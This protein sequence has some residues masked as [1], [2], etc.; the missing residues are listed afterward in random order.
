MSRRAALITTAAPSAGEQLARRRRKYVVMMACRIPCLV[1]AG[2]TAHVWWLALAFLAISVPLPWAAVLIAN[3][4]PARRAE[5]V[6]RVP[7][8]SR[9]PGAG[10]QG[11]G[12]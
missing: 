6:D 4:V 3:D 12:E 5:R 11:S 10:R 7:L 9:S 1:L 2:L 8:P